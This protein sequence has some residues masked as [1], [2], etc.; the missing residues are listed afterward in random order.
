M[1]R[2]LGQFLQRGFPTVNDF[3][4]MTVLG[5]CCDDLP[6]HWKFIFNDQDSHE[7]IRNIGCLEADG[8]LGSQQVVVTARS[9][10]F[11]LKTILQFY[12]RVRGETVGSR[13]ID[14]AKI[15]TPVFFTPRAKIDCVE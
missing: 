10:R 7:S 9:R 13:D 5:Q 1:K 14:S 11:M 6:R 2:P 8:K 15:W 12:L 4:I 3:R